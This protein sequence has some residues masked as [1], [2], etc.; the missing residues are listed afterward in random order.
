MD[1]A[2]GK[3]LNSR[4]V[5]DDSFYTHTSQLDSDRGKYAI[6][7]SE[8][9]EFWEVYCDRFQELGSDFIAG[10]SERP[11][12]YMPLL[13]DID[14]KFQVES[15]ESFT[16]HF[17]A[18]RHIEAL[19]KIYMDV[20]KYVVG[21]EWNQNH[22]YCFV[23]EK[24]KPAYKGEDIGDGFHLHFPFVYFNKYDY[25]VHIVP[26]IEDRIEKEGIFNDIVG[27]GDKGI[28]A[29]DKGVNEKYWIV[30]GG[31]KSA[32]KE[33]YIVSKI[34][35]SRCC[36]ATLEEVMKNNILPDGQGQRIK[37]D[38]SKPLEYYLPRLLSVKNIGRPTYSARPDIECI[39]KTK[40]LKANQIKGNVENNLS[41]PQAIELCRILVPMLSIDRAT[42]RDTWMNVGWCIYSI[43]QGCQ[44]GLEIWI[45]FSKRSNKGNF[46][47]AICVYEWNYKMHVGG[48]TV[49][50]LRMWCAQD[51]PDAYA[52]FKLEE[53]RKHILNSL[54]GGHFDFARMLYDLCGKDFVCMSIQSNIWYEFINHKWEQLDCA[55][56]LRL[57]IQNEILPRY[58]EENKT[59]LDNVNAVEGRGADIMVK[60]AKLNKIIGKLKDNSFQNGIMRECSNLFYKKDFYQKLDQDKYLIC[61]NN[62]VL[63]L[64][65]GCFRDGKPEDFLSMSTGYDWKEFEWDDAE[66]EDVMRFFEKIFPDPDKRT[67]FLEWAG[68]LFK[69]GN[70][71]KNFLVMSGSGDNGKSIIIDFLQLVLG[72]YAITF[73]T[74]L[75]TGKQTQSSAAT[76]E[77][78]RAPGARF[79]V[80]QEPD[81]KAQLNNGVLKLLTG[82]D[83]FFV[84]GLFKEGKD[85]R[86]LYKL[87]FICNQLPKL[88]SEDNA[89]WERVRRLTFESRFPKNPFEVP[90]TWA[91]Q[92][93]KKVFPRD[94]RL[95]EKLP[96]M[97]QAFAWIMFQMYKRVSKKGFT[98]EP[99]TVIEA[100]RLYRQLNDFYL[101][102]LNECL[103]KDE[104]TETNKD[105]LSLNELWESFRDWFHTS[106]SGQKCPGRNEMKDEMTKKLGMMAKNNKWTKWRLKTEKDE[107]AEGNALEMN[108]EDFT[109]YDTETE[110]ESEE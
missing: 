47:E 107:V 28:K 101:Q 11:R 49:G 80:L 66:V 10:V 81:G 63:D 103:V 92:L 36:R 52:A 77:L 26:R 57:K 51:N 40:L 75:L 35:N 46:N 1:L 70:E 30:Y 105:G 12:E 87:A 104:N 42:A 48:Y 33:P 44:E 82:N 106:M 102:Y 16:T 14:F 76:P 5:F 50:T 3:F 13:V 67:Y 74:T 68:S 56:T 73:P 37:L 69:G 6:D 96:Y 20:I 84:R 45:N 34:Y 53:Q 31:R 86:P 97:K 43:T 7:V 89:T 64:K 21:N 60:V 59:L 8:E 72:E 71:S 2:V 79:S 22:L 93:Q 24:S 98:P 41:V 108:E 85:I 90:L 94:S 29:F 58:V 23:L 18:T 39:S 110:T 95:N 100:T 32:V 78:A 65:M 27:Y 83:K 25:E 4:K 9:D 61:F 99:E 17:Y 91:E 54:D 19:V 55:V 15:G 88:P 38:P 109:D 62:G